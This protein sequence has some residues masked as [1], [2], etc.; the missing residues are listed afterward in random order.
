MAWASMLV[1]SL[2]LFCFAILPLAR[3]SGSEPREVGSAA[4]RIGA[5]ELRIREARRAAAAA[6]AVTGGFERV[7]GRHRRR[8]A[9]LHLRER[10][11]AG[12]G[13]AD[14]AVPRAADD[15]P[16]R[17]SHSQLAAL[18]G[19]ELATLRDLR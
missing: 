15:D 18:L 7:E 2:K 5:R 1:R 16:P 10:H 9:R 12:A 19:P 11:A 3:A 8:L 14:A 4:A 17:N 6:A 13:L